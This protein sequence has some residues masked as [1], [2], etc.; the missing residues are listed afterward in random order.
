MGGRTQGTYL[1]EE[2]NTDNRHQVGLPVCRNG[3]GVMAN[4]CRACECVRRSGCEV[5]VERRSEN[6]RRGIN[7]QGDEGGSENVTDGVCGVVLRGIQE[8]GEDAI[9]GGVKEIDQDD[10]DGD[11]DIIDVHGGRRGEDAEIEKR[12]YE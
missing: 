2:C 10:S 5:G 12:E 11:E 6:R 7:G 1:D 8:R 9:V 3:V 4:R